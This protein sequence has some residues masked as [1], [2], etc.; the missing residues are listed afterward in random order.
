MGL[1][2]PPGYSD[3]ALEEARAALPDVCVEKAVDVRR[4]M[5]FAKALGV[6]NR[7]AYAVYFKMQF[8]QARA[9]LLC[10]PDEQAGPEPGDHAF[11]GG[12]HGGQ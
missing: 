11:T 5:T 4:F 9:G 1:Q 8:W 2:H 7:E 3:E 12:D 10:Y 6:A